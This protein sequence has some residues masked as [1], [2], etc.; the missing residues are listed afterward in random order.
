MGTVLTALRWLLVPICAAFACWSGIALAVLLFFFFNSRCPP[1][2]LVSGFCTASWFPVVE[3]GTQLI[4]AC[5]G[6]AL[7]VLLPYLL[8]PSHKRAVALTAFVL[9]AIY[10]ISFVLVGFDAWPYA[11]CAIATGLLVLVKTRAHA[12]H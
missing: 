12:A 3:A 6:A 9:G 2:L 4:G 7:A 8:A 11:A 1:E 10:S 5:A